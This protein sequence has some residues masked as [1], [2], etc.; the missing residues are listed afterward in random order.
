VRLTWDESNN[1]ASIAIVD[2][3]LRGRAH[4]A[5][6]VSDDVVFDLDGT[7]RVI[8]IQ[9]LDPSRILEGVSTADEALSRVLGSLATLQAS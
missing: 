6:R 9:I 8:N 2:A 7:G 3:D 4:D 5:W 1:V